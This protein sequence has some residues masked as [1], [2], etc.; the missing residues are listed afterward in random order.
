MELASAPFYI[1]VVATLLCIVGVVFY[2]KHPSSVSMPEATAQAAVHRA[3]ARRQEAMF[4]AAY[5]A[6]WAQR[7]ATTA[8]APAAPGA[9][10]PAA[11]APAPGAPAPVS[12]QV[13]EP[14]S[15]PAA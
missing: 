5:Q 9:P 7:L 1:L 8:G 10:Q 12:D 15:A 13:S 2:V 11:A 6:G 4:Q 3:R 14:P